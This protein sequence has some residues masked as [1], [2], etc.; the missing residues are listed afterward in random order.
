MDDASCAH[1]KFTYLLIFTF[2]QVPDLQ[3][4]LGS[5]Y[6]KIYPRIIVRQH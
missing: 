4:I 6:D 3:N 5:S 1:Y 2:K